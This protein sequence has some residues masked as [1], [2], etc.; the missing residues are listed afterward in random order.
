MTDANL[1]RYLYGAGTSRRHHVALFRRRPA[2]TPD[3]LRF[4][5]R[6]EEADRARWERL[7]IT[8]L[9]ADHFAD[10]AQFVREVA[11]RRRLGTRYRPVPERIE[12]WFQREGDG[13]CLYCEDDQGYEEVQ[14]LLH[15][16]LERLGHDVRRLLAASGVNLAGEKLA[17]ALLS[18]Y[19]PAADGEPERVVVL[20]SSDRIMTAVDSIAPI[21]LED[22][23]DWTGVKVICRGVPHDEAKDNYASRWRYVLGFPVYTDGVRTPLGAV[24]IASMSPASALAFKGLP[25]ESRVALAEVVS[26]RA[27]GLLTLAG[28][29]F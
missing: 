27:Q 6:A 14:E 29:A 26:E 25:A 24:T 16:G 22:R 2:D 3:E 4:R 9:F 18:L 1:I 20:A 17:L 11:Y 21:R 10:V 15:D 7:G 12:D 28:D 8:P 19:P 23:S 5:D 13:G